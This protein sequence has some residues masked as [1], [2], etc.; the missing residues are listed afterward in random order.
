MASDRSRVRA[1]ACG[2]SIQPLARRPFAAASDD[3]ARVMV[4]NPPFVV[5]TNKQIARGQSAP[6][7]LFLAQHQGD[8]A[9]KKHLLVETGDAR[10]VGV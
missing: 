2:G 8:I 1:A 7:Q 5:F 4:C 9:V 3:L 10:G 6:F